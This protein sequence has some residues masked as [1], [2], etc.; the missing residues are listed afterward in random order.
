MICV[1]FGHFEAL[2]LFQ[3]PIKTEFETSE[4]DT[5]L[6]SSYTIKPLASTMSYELFAPKLLKR[7]MKLKIV[8]AERAKSALETTFYF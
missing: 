5:E 8:N 3:K 6:G 2:L 4:N 1:Y 7:V